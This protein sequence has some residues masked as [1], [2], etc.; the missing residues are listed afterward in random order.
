M[1]NTYNKVEFLVMKIALIF[2]NMW[3]KLDDYN[4]M[5]SKI[6][7]I[8]SQNMDSNIGKHCGET[9]ISEND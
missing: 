3:Q 7:F 4:R 9:L 8:M 2:R 5:M 6:V 1:R